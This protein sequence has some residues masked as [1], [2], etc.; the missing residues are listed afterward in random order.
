MSG[1]QKQQS[2]SSASVSLPTSNPVPPLSPVENDDD[3]DDGDGSD[4][5]PSNGI[6]YADW[7]GSSKWPPSDRFKKPNAADLV[8]AVQRRCEQL[9]Q[10]N[11]KPSHWRIQ[12]CVDYLLQN[13][14][15]G[16]PPDNS[17]ISASKLFDD[18]KHHVIEEGR[19]RKKEA[20]RKASGAP[21][22]DAAGGHKD[23]RF[24]SAATKAKLQDT[25]PK[26]KI[27]HFE[28]FKVAPRWL[29]LRIETTNGVVGW[30]EPNVEGFSDTVEAAVRELMKSIL[31]ED[32]SRIQYIWQKFYRQKF[33][34]GGPILMSAMA[35]I[36][37]ALWDIAGK[38]LGVPVHRML[39]GAVRKRLRVY[40][41][42]GGDDNTPTEAASEASAVIK[43]S[44]YKQLKMNACSR[45]AYID[46]DKAIEAAAARFRAVREAVGPDIGIG[47][48]FHGRVKLPMVKKMMDA[49]A[50]YDPLFFEEP[51][52]AGQNPALKSVQEATSV[53]IATG[54]RMYTVEAYRS[55]LEQRAANIIQPDCSHAGGISQML[56]LARMAEAYDV[57]FAPHCP[58]GPIA[59]ASCLQVDA[60]AVNFVFQETS[61][62][63]HYNEEG[64]VDLLDYVVN[65]SALEVDSEGFMHLL[66]KPGLGIEIDEDKVRAMAAKGHAWRDREWT[67]TDSCPTTW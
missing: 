3:G 15:D 17:C 20:R 47:L 53:P 24:K 56:T 64:G 23:K 16:V 41:W 66:D 37:Q 51:I 8:G 48:D 11:V 25:P 63:I 38:T 2:G 35:G 9:G 55:L 40:R 4:T 50:P 29:F 27:E 10:G 33:Y 32:P 61:M 59:L 57:S 26:D 18:A 5:E 14:I 19:R 44:N 6:N 1:V 34:S 28:L 7:I 67:L 13:T 31:G 30:G 42:F 45:M 54:E 36:D 65:K 21:A 49:L 60:C 12:R 22:G 62:G 39:G 58:L 43:K 52:T 46:T